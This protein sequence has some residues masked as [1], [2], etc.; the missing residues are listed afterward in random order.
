M[1]RY[2]VE[3]D[4]NELVGMVVSLYDE[5]TEGQPMNIEKVNAT[6]NEFFINPQKINIF[7]IISE[8]KKVVGYSFVVYYWSNEHGGDI[9]NIDELYIKEE[10]RGKGIGTSFINALLEKKSIVALRLE[11]TPT[12]G[13]AFDYYKRL[14]FS[15]SENNHL[16]KKQCFYANYCQ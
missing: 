2:Y 4:Y 10:F 16:I 8:N 1:F 11:T 9:L 7:M 5:D 14:G 13:R 12:N 3:D 15:L 6:I